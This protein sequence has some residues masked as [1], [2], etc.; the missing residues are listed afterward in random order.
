M[1]LLIIYSSSIPKYNT[2]TLITVSTSYSAFDASKYSINRAYFDSRLIIFKIESYSTLISRSF[3]F[4]N[5]V[6]KSIITIC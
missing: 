6:I 4:G 5:L 3:D 2:S 1:S